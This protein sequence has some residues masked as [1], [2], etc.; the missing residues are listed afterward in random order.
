ML[1]LLYV[2][3]HPANIALMIR[4]ARFGGF[5]IEVRTSGEETLRDFH[6][7]NPDVLLI[8]IQLAGLL[9]G[10]DVVR[11]LRADGVTL[12][13]IAVTAYA[14]IG[15]RE[16]ALDAGCDDYIAKPIPVDLLIEKLKAY[17]TAK[18]EKKLKGD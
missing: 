11:K 13:I 17:E 10:L 12:P 2:E 18:S 3:D 6:T 8:D 15:D 7:L 16:K 4:I 5:E 1:Q 9:T 14:M